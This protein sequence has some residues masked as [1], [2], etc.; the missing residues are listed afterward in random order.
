MHE[1][2]I[3]QSILDT[4]LT[5]KQARDLDTVESVT[6][7]VG[8]MSG[9]LPDALQFCFEAIRIDTPLDGC[10]MIIEPVPIR[11]ACR[12]C[13]RSTTVDSFLFVCPACESVHVDVIEGYD[14]EIAYIEVPDPVEAPVT[15]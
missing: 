15:Q 3:A 7:R 10:D 6:V 1:L 5:E 11:I 12:A 2:S 9:V 8:A 13:D 14:L 4:V